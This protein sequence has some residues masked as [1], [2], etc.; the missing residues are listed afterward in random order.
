MSAA[1]VL[2][3]EMFFKA[4]NTAFVMIFYITIPLQQK[5]PMGMS[6][7][8][9]GSAVSDPDPYPAI[10]TPQISSICMFLK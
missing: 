5:I 10:S 9:S 3:L 6:L 8:L 2:Y 1:C 7:S 4:Q